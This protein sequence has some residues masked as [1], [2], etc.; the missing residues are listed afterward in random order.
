VRRVLFLIVALLVSYFWV[1]YRWR[2]EGPQD[3]EQIVEF[4]RGSHLNDIAQQLEAS[5]AIANRWMFLAGLHL[6]PAGRNLKAGEYAIAAGT[7]MADIAALLRSGKVLLH[8]VTLVEGRTVAEAVA[9]LARLDILNGV[10]APV[11]KEGSLCPNTYLVARHTERRALL[12]RMAAAQEALIQELWRSDS[13][14]AVIRNT[15]ELLILASIVEKE[16]GRD[17]ERARVAAVFE[18]R[19]A[20]HMRLQSDP[21]VAYGLTSG[22]AELMRDL[23]R[24]DLQRLT[25]WNT[26]LVDGLPPTPISNPGR[27][28]LE[29][30]LKPAAGDELYFVAD[31]TGGHIFA[32]TLDEHNRNV[33]K[34]RQFQSDH[35]RTDPR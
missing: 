2:A 32:R 33:A 7:S 17:D 25:P 12:E 14:P 22:T 29:A 26:Y 34:Y 27:K 4:P 6:D 31:G 9:E 3:H 8:R 21:T 16:T 20:R 28:S 35:G 15:E 13:T 5:G 19:L 30:V 24:D 18:N 1:E 23:T 11:P 10:A